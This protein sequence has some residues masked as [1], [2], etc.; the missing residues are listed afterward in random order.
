MAN[1]HE[2]KSSTSLII[3]DMK[4]KMISV[5]LKKLAKIFMV[6]FN[7]KWS[8]NKKILKI[9]IPAQFLL[10]NMF[11]EKEDSEISKYISSTLL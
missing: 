2:M 3:K 1:K 9:Y 11:L 7:A 10:L 6:I 8:I 4:T 5:F